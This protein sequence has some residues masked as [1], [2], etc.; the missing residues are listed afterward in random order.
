M[1]KL[2]SRKRLGT[3]GIRGNNHSD[4]TQ[5]GCKLVT[6]GIKNQEGDEKLDAR[7]EM[8]KQ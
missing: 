6:S 3:L 5:D 4:I 8:S 7:G 2:K 1:K